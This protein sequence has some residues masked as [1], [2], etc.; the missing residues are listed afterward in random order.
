MGPSM[1]SLL[2]FMRGASAQGSRGADRESTPMDGEAATPEG[3]RNGGGSIFINLIILMMMWDGVG[4]SG[5]EGEDSRS[6]T[7]EGIEGR[8]VGFTPSLSQGPPWGGA[9]SQ[10]SF[11]SIAENKHNSSFIQ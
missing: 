11:L 5:K 4:N 3:E 9:S 1:A 6:L 7:G 10:S 2:V 8:G